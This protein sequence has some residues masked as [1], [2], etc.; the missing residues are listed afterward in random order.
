MARR[1]GDVG[2]AERECRRDVREEMDLRK[3]MMVYL[4][5]IVS[6]LGVHWFPTRDPAFG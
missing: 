4:M 3:E 5:M 1:V 6:S 2:L